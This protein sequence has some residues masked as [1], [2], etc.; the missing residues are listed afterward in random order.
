MR[1]VL[2]CSSGRLEFR[3]VGDAVCITASTSGASENDMSA[4]KSSFPS[5]KSRL[6]LH[7]YIERS[8]SAD[9]RNFHDLESVPEL[10]QSFLHHL[11]GSERPNSSSHVVPLLEETTDYSARDMPIDT[12]H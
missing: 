3:A 8:S 7:D 12:S 1:R 2:T 5:E 9:I 10:R 4:A 6:T 11:C